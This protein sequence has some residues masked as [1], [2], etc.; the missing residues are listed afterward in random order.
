MKKT[1]L[2]EVKHFV[3]KNREKNHEN[4][5]I[6]NDLQQTTSA[7]KENFT[8]MPILPNYENQNTFS[9]PAIPVYSSSI[10]SE[11]EEFLKKTE[12]KFTIKELSK[13]LNLSPPTLYYWARKNHYCPK[14][15]NKHSP[16]SR[17]LQK[18]LVKQLDSMSITELANTYAIPYH[19]LY[20]WI[21][22]QH[23]TV[24]KSSEFSPY[25]QQELRKKCRISSLNVLAQEYGLS[26]QTM[27]SRLKR[28]DCFSDG[29]GGFFIADS[30]INKE[31]IYSYQ[32]KGLEETAKNFH[33]T[34]VAIKSYLKKHECCYL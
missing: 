32:E 14:N 12:G 24:K 6:A 3:S 17:E 11:T 34:K 1:T 22:K 4:F 7:I 18:T 33:T 19:T 20:H 2:N 25:I 5:S 26:E 13:K 15:G 10:S 28:I 9:Y 16:I 8:A 29:K 30:L 27:R 21:K 31:I 23:L